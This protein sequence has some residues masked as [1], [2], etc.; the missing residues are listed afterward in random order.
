M[1]DVGFFLLVVFS[2]YCGLVYNAFYKTF[3][4]EGAGFF[5]AAIAL[6]FFWIFSTLGLLVEDIIVIRRDELVHARWTCG[7]IA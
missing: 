5:L 7:Y 2:G 3:A 1:S 4:R 6:F